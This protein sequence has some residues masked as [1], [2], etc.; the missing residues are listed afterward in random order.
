MSAVKKGDLVVGLRVADGVK[1]LSDE[2]GVEVDFGTAPSK[3][4]AAAVGAF[5]A[6]E[7]VDVTGITG[8]L[9]FNTTGEVCAPMAAFTLDASGASWEKIAVFTPDCPATTGTWPAVP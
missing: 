6:S 2:T 4:V 1:K 9:D 8:P 7:T 3:F 5:T